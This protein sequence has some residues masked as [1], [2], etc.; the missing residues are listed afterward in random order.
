MHINDLLRPFFSPHNRYLPALMLIG[1]FSIFAYTN[2]IQILASTEDDAKII[3]TSGRQRML[4]Q[5]LILLGLNYLNNKTEANKK[6]LATNI[7]LMRHSHSYLISGTKNSELEELYEKQQLS[8]KI[9]DFLNNFDIFLKNSSNTLITKLSLDAQELLPL[10]SAVVKEYEKI[11][12]QKVKELELRQFY[13]LV[14]T[15]ILLSLELI[16]IFYPASKQIKNHTKELEKK[17]Q[18]ELSKNR[19]KDRQLAQHSR[20]AQM[21]EM[22]SIIAHQWRQPLGTISNISS[23]IQLEAMLKKLTSES[24]IKHTKKISQLIEHLSQT[25]DDFRDFFKPTKQKEKIDCDE[26]IRS[27]LNIVESSLK[28]N[29][30]KFIQ[31]LMCN[32][33]LYTYENELKQVMLSLITNAQDALVKNKIKNPYIKISSSSDNDFYIFEVSDN[34]GGVDESVI[35]HIFNPYFTTKSKENGTGLG[36]YMSKTIIEDHCQGTLSISNSDEGAIFKITIPIRE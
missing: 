3:N 29:N 10:L 26:I 9:E 33:N 6:L 12:I 15:L 36:L 16:F 24:A 34:G 20:L 8:K 13:I 35:E 14:L 17:V 30:I 27:I 25:I 7:E 11:N 22:I 5:N 28:A 18:E 31:E 23:A 1:L 32:N 21:G 2:V 4:S 19:Q